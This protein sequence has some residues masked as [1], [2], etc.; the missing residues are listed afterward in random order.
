MSQVHTIVKGDTRS[1]LLLKLL[2]GG[3]PVDL[4]G[5]TVKV[6]GEDNDST[7]WITETAT[8]VTAHPTNAFTAS[9]STD[10]LSHNATPVEDGDQVVLATS[11]TL[12][13]GTAASTRYFVI[14]KEPNAFQISLTPNGSAVDITDTGTGSHTYYIV[15]S[16]AYAWQTADVDTAGT[17]W[18]WARVFTSASVYDTFPVV[19]V[20]TDRGFMVEIVEVS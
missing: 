12:P 14:N 13:A 16:V 10:K 11:G 15:G 2:Q 20:P 6:V 8:G 17:F 19:R 1:S 9:A 4:A 18:L 3:Q 5:L 7:A